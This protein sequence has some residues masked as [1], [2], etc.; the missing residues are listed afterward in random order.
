MS[1]FQYLLQ[2]VLDICISY[3]HTVFNVSG[4]RTQLDPANVYQNTICRVRFKFLKFS[5]IFT[6]KLFTYFFSQKRKTS[7]IFNQSWN[8]YCMRSIC[9]A[10]IFWIGY[11]FDSKFNLYCLLD[12]MFS[13][14]MQR[15]WKIG[16]PGMDITEIVNWSIVKGS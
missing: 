10:N 4:N 8:I 12:Q 5:L 3:L 14:F 2:N 6:L 11:S 9:Y 1:F 7:R 16:Q 13:V 15:N